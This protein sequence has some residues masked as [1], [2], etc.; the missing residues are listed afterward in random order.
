MGFPLPWNSF[1]EGP[2][3]FPVHGNV[4][5]PARILI[6]Q[7]GNVDQPPKS[8]FEPLTSKLES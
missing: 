1:P 4:T 2:S 3:G 8:D 6:N 7:N 5:I